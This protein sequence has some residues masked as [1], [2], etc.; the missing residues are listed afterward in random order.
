[1]SVCEGGALFPILLM[2]EQ[3]G[4]VKGLAQ[5]CT[6]GWGRAGAARLFCG[7]SNSHRVRACPRLMCLA[8]LSPP[9]HPGEEMV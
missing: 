9:S 2:R 4:M 3:A 8:S 6:A 5:G 7:W 1:M